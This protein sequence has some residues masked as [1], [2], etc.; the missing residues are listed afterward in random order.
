MIELYSS[1]ETSEATV[2]EENGLIGFCH[3]ATGLLLLQGKEKITLLH[4]L[5]LSL[6]KTV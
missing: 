5:I 4:Y 3:N 6:E 2:T 1:I